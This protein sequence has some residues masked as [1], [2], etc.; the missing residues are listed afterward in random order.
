MNNKSLWKKYFPQLVKQPDEAIEKLIEQAQVV[1]LP[2]GQMVFHAGSACE[3]YLLVLEG[4]VRTQLVTEQGREVVLYYVS[5]GQ[6]CVL[7][8]SCLLSHQPYPFEGITDGEVKAL[9]IDKTAFEYALEHSSLFRKFVFDGFSQRL[10]EVI[11]RMQQV[12]FG[13]IDRRLAEVLVR[14]GPVSS[15][16]HQ[17][18]ATEVGSAREVVSRHLKRFEDKGWVKLGRGVIEVRDQ[19]SLVKLMS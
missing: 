15:I 13:S 12:A 10:A 2:A 17:A 6:S 19:A 16:T 8:T 14:S 4:K 7:T 5:S 9:S 1:S 11:A 3:K 18:L